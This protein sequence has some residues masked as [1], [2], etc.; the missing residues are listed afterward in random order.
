MQRPQMVR[1]SRNLQL[2]RLEEL[3]I[4]A[5]Q[6]ASDLATQQYSRPRKDLRCPIGSRSDLRRT[7]VLP[8]LERVGHALCT[9]LRRCHIKSL[10]AKDGQNIVEAALRGLLRH[11][12]HQLLDS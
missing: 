5:V 8:H 9:V 10:T 4:P 3:L 2:R 7:P 6:Q 1:R 12:C 11:K